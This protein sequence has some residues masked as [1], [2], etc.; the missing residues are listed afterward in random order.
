MTSMELLFDEFMPCRR[1]QR[2]AMVSRIYS[3]S[4][5]FQR[6]VWHCYHWHPEKRLNFT[7]IIL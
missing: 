4:R 5:Q 7:T 2:H 1:L 6:G 3:H